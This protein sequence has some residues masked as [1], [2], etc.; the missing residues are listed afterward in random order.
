IS[1]DIQSIIQGIF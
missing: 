1:D